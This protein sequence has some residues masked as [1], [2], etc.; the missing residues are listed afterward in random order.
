MPFVAVVTIV[1]AVLTVLALAG[2][3]IAVALILW[4][5]DRRLTSI[6]AGV[7]VITAKAAPAGPV[8]REINRD[9][10]GVNNALQGVLGKSRQPK[11]RP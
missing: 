3:L 2:F 4:R 1:G 10:T 6:T 5:V 9:L 11:F 7:G 8:V